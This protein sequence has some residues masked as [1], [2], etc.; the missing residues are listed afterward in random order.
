[1]N[2]F[3]LKFEA[4]GNKILAYF[5]GTYGTNAA[6]RYAETNRGVL[7]PLTAGTSW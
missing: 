6:E 4:G 5:Y 1:M 3:G 2:Y 7:L